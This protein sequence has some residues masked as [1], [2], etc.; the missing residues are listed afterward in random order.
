MKRKYLLIVTLALISIIFLSGCKPKQDKPTGIEVIYD[1]NGG[2]FQNCTLPIRQYYNYTDNAKHII[3]DPETLVED[4]IQKSGYILEGWYTD[5][6]FTRKWDFENDEITVDGLTLYAKW[7]KEIKYTYN[8]CYV[9]EKTG[10]TVIINT[11]NVEEGQK[12]EDYRRYA[13]KRS[14]YTPLRFYKEN[15]EDWDF[16]FT[17]PGGD[18]DLA[19]N[20]YVEYIEGEYMLVST[21]EEF[22]I[23]VDKGENIYLLNDI[24]LENSIIEFGDFSNQVFTGRGFTVSNFK[25]VKTISYPQHLE[26]DHTDES[27]NSAYVSLFG[28]VSNSVIENV[29]FENVQ[30]EISVSPARTYR[31]YLAPLTTSSE[32]SKL[33]NVTVNATYKCIQLPNGFDEKENFKI[34]AD[35]YITSFE[36]TIYHE[37]NFTIEKGE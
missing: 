35:K 31:I 1:L 4:V 29:T 24:D 18:T 14:G 22:I 3:M 23:A 15:G 37:L 12:F 26:I 33:V 13:E 25:V 11:Y 19:I 8:V 2:I 27:K 32:N 9:D 10:Q 7:E 36:E 21:K 34:Y 16:E 28:N 30:F 5:Q 6:E 17:H 20:V